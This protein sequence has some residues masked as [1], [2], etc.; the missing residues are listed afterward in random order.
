MILEQA[1]REELTDIVQLSD[2]Y[3]QV[4]LLS[5]RCERPQVGINHEASMK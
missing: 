5:P 4:I 1:L 3:A 2:L